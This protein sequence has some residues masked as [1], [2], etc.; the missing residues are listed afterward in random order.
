[1]NEKERLLNVLFGKKVDRPPVIAPG[2]MMASLTEE[3][4]RTCDLDPIRSVTDATEMVR[5]AELV[6]KLTGFESLGLPFCLTVEAKALGAQVSSGTSQVEPLLLGPAF[7]GNYDDL[8]TTLIP[9]PFAEKCMAEVL[10][11][12]RIL[13]LQNP[14]VPVIGNL[15]GP[16]TLAASLI[17][18]NEFFRMLLRDPTK[19]GKIIDIAS[20][21]IIGFGL[22][23]E[24]SGVDVIT[25]SD[26]TACGKIIGPKI[27]EDILLLEFQRIFREI[28]R[29]DVG[30]IL[31]ICGNVTNLLPFIIATGADAFSIDSMM[32]IPRVRQAILPMAVMG[33]L[34]TLLLAKGTPETVSDATRRV[35]DQK[36][37]ILSPSC[38]LDRR[39]PLKNI[40]AMCDT[41][42]SKNKMIA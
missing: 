35:L 11:G 2:G 20:Q 36:V 27:F 32:P 18:E 22:A 34:S 8:D 3:I 10:D 37:N 21:T 39:T 29:H 13:K 19:A 25:I 14:D 40:Q 42:K 1:M 9:Q 12:I 16:I 7:K 31:H 41:A 15:T 4:F 28:K 5:A 38:G 30:T 6:R 33:N 17:P 24:E 26:P 23:M